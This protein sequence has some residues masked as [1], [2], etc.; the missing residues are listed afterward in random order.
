MKLSIIIPC[1]R[2]EKYI[3]KCL[4]SVLSIPLNDSEYEVICFEDCAPDNTPTILDDYVYRYKNVKIVHSAVNVGPGGGRNQALKNA[5]GRYVWFVDADDMVI[6]DVV[7]SLLNQAEANHLDVLIFDYQEINECENI[8]PKGYNMKDTCVMHGDE[9]ANL[10]FEGGLVNNM[11]YPW[12]FLIKREYLC[13]NRIVFPENMMY[14]EDTVW[15]GKVVLF[16]ERIQASSKC[17]YLYWHH[18]TST[19]GIMNKYYP[20]RTIYER[21]ILTAKQLFDFV[22]E[23]KDRQSPNLEVYAAQIDFF[24]RNHYVNQLPIMMGRTSRQERRIFYVMW[25]AHTCIKIKQRANFITQILLMP[26]YGCIFADLFA[27]YYKLT[28]RKYR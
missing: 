15:M 27:V 19:C 16:A 11:G 4:D 7:P 1:Y 2:V 3:R 24:A 21:C 14:G 8:L 5:I 17:A 13:Q 18:E 20:G 28:H 25:K 6:P 12:R 23:L 22:E 10:A 9:I 26:I